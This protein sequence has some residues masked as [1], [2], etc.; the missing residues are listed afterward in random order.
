MSAGF[1]VLSKSIFASVAFFF[2]YVNSTG[3]PFSLRFVFIYSAG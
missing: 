3:N 2:R 1:A